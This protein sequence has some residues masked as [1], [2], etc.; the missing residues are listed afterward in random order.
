M[1]EEKLKF[2]FDGEESKNPLLRFLSKN[3]KSIANLIITHVATCVFGLIV[4]IACTMVSGQ[5]WGKEGYP[6]V[7]IH[8]GG[9]ISALLYLMVIYVHMW[10]RGA[11]DKNKIDA[12]RLKKDKLT[13]L[14][15]WLVPNFIIILLTIFSTLFYFVWQNGSG[16]V[17]IVLRFINGM[18][19]NLLSLAKVPPFA[20]YWIV[21]VPGMLVATLSYISGVSGQKCLFP[22]PKN[23]NKKYR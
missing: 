21:L 3:S 6:T 5:V 23:S 17:D 12:G 2:D 9:T 20:M 8:I 19:L 11:N 13:G 14:K 18:Y 7:I 10:E 22:E 16:I 4:V 15:I 1:S